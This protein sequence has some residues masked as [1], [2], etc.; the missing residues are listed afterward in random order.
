[1]HVNAAAFLLPAEFA[2]VFGYH[3]GFHFN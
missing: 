3:C 2:T 1:L